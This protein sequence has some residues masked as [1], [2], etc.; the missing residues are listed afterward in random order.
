MMRERLGKFALPE[1]YREP[2][3]FDTIPS[4]PI[5]HACSNTSGPSCSM[6]SLNLTPSPARA[7]SFSSAALRR[8]SGP[9]LRS[10]P[11]SS[12]MSRTPT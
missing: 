8:S 7:S 12:R 9:R 6:C 1:L 5:R 2:L 4:R 3:R 11:L 10:L